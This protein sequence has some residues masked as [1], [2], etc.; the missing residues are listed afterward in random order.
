MNKSNMMNIIARISLILTIAVFFILVFNV[1]Y[2]ILSILV[3]S[4]NIKSEIFYPVIGALIPIVLLINMIILLHA[5]DYKENL[6]F[7]YSLTKNDKIK[8]AIYASL[9]LLNTM[10]LYLHTKSYNHPVRIL[11]IIQCFPLINI[12]VYKRLINSL[13]QNGNENN[14]VHQYFKGSLILTIIRKEKA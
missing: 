7:Y 14:F 4:F 11:G 8:I 1:T 10:L 12:L 9:G 2:L 5:C 3:W 13:K 6:I